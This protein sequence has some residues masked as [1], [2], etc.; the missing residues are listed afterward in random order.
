MWKQKVK[1]GRLPKLAL[2]LWLKLIRPLLYLWNFLSKKT[3]KHDMVNCQK[4]FHPSITILMEA[5]TF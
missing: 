2:G 1:D 5:K 4:R 3:P